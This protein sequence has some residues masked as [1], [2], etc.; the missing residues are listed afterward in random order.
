MTTE[1]KKVPRGAKWLFMR[2]RVNVIKNGRFDMEIHIV[3]ESGE[4]VAICKHCAM[5]VEGPL[6]GSSDEIRK[7]YKL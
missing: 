6:A 7:L 1:I 5:V 4:L 2:S 3:D